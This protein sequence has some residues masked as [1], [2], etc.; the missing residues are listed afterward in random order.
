MDRDELIMVKSGATPEELIRLADQLRNFAVALTSVEK[1]I[2]GRLSTAPWTGPSADRFRSDWSRVYRCQLRNSSQLLA[3][4]ETVARRNAE[5][6]LQASAAAGGS[7]SAAAGT[8]FVGL[9]TS[10]A[11]LPWLSSLPAAGSTPAQ[12]ADWWRGLSSLQQH[13]LLTE[14]PE[15]I[16]N[17]N[18]LPGAVRDQANRSRINTE[19]AALRAQ[20]DGLRQ[21]LDRDPTGGLFTNDDRQLELVEAKLK[22]LD[23]IDSTLDLGNRQL[24]LLDMSDERAMAAIATGDVDTA[25]HIAVFTPGLSTTVEGDIGNIDRQMDQLR[26]TSRGISLSLGSSDNTSAVT[27]I[28]YQTPQWHDIGDLSRSVLSDAAARRG[29]TSLAGFLDGIDASRR[30]D[31]SDVHLTALGYSYGSTT[32]GH[33]LLS[34]AASGHSVTDHAVFFGSPG[35]GT[36]NVADLGLAPGRAFVIEARSDPVADAAWFGGD[37]DHLPGISHLSSGDTARGSGST[38]HFAQLKQGSTSQFNISA[39]IVGHPEIAISGSNHDAGDLLRPAIGGI[40]P[41]FGPLSALGGVGLGVRD[42]INNW[43]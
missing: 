36:N 32:T 5:E 13:R 26:E 38:G 12:N 43:R 31:G 37:P 41:A 9:V 21:R 4:A 40:A 8:A 7:I 33:A 39:V 24:L 10:L 30:A 2:S 20:A 28:G 14:H 23:E 17:L 18:G 15:L 3:D 27:W 25:Q 1:S 19:R 34:A 6:Q 11:S 29:G 16:G 22:A 35:I 42:A